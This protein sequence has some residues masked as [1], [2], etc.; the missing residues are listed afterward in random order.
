LQLAQ[1]LECVGRRRG[2]GLAAR[3]FEAG[4]QLHLAAFELAS[5]ELTQGGLGLPQLIGQAQAQV[6]KA[7]VDR[8]QLQAQ[9]GAA[10]GIG[11]LQRP[12]HG[13]IACHAEDGHFQLPSCSR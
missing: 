11:A 1:L 7:A 13:G 10:L 3:A 9:H 4:A 6:Q 8:T 12:L 2:G 5:D